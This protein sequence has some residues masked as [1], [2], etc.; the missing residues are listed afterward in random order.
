[1]Y[2]KKLLT[3]IISVM[4]LERFL[5][6]IGPR[7]PDGVT[8]SVIDRWPT[9]PLLIKTFAQNIRQELDT[10]PENIRKKVNIVTNKHLERPSHR[11]FAK[12]WT[13]TW[14]T[15]ERNGTKNKYFQHSRQFKKDVN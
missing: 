12:S 4:Q 13:P 2:S 11:T 1:M 8:W 7:G 6:I 14:R 15:S 10:F 3:I 9:H 5:F